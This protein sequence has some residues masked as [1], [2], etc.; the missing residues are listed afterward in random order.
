MVI[1]WQ[2]QVVLRKLTGLTRAMIL[3][4]WCRPAKAFPIARLI[5]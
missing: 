2:L 1:D 3:D 5:R 4:P